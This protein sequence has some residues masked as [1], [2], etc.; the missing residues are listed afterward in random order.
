LHSGVLSGSNPAAGGISIS[1]RRFAFTEGRKFP[2]LEMAREPDSNILEKSFY[3]ANIQIN[4][5]IATD[6]AIYES[7]PSAKRKLWMKAGSDP[8]DELVNMQSLM[9]FIKGKKYFESFIEVPVDDE[10]V[11]YRDSS[12]PF[13]QYSEKSL[14][15]KRTTL[16]YRLISKKIIEIK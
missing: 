2:F 9:S 11:K 15:E 6:Y 14:I 3:F 10:Q 4:E 16:D 7:V 13:L 1:E 12:T 8:T 5:I